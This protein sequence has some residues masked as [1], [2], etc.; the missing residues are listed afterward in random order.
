MLLLELATDEK[1]KETLT[2]KIADLKEQSNCEN[3]TTEE[4]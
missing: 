3:T 1:I 2:V 4:V